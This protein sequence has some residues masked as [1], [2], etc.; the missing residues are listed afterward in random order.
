MPTPCV[1]FTNYTSDKLLT[2][3]AGQVL[4]G[5]VFLRGR[6][7]CREWA[8]RVGFV[9]Q[10]MRQLLW[11][12]PRENGYKK[13]ACPAVSS[14]R[15]A[16]CLTLL[17]GCG[18]AWSVLAQ[19]A[20]P[21]SAE[22]E[23]DLLG[24]SH[25][26]NRIP[27]VEWLPKPQIDIADANAD[28]ETAMKPYSEFIPGDDKKFDMVP[29]P[30]GQFSMGSPENEVGRSPNEGPQHEVRIAPFWMGKCE[31]TWDEFDLWML[32]LDHDLRVVGRR[33]STS[34]VHDKLADALAVP[35]M[36]YSDPTCSMGHEGYP[37]ILMT[38]LSAKLYCKWLSAK[39]GR[40]YR[41]P[42]EAEWEY[43]CR[44][45]TRTAYHFGDDPKELEQ[46]A[47]YAENSNEK[48][49]KVGQKKPNAWGLYDM[50]GNV[51]E[52]VLDGV[53]LDFY[54]QSA[55]HVVT[56]PF[57]VPTSTYGRGAR[58]GSWCDEAE[59][60][61]SAARRC[62]TTDWD[63]QNQ[64]IPGRPTWHTDS[65]FVGFRVVRPLRLPSV[66]ECEKLESR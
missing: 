60:L 57:A 10:V 12:C 50:H 63:A 34:I 13:M 47:W 51:A 9:Q 59:K 44:A 14:A 28:N 2:P 43:A 55:G 19:D 26:L 25:S 41:L 7:V 64:M 33:V 18:G 56:E 37:A 36:P 46:Y 29:I 6:G 42:T 20:T 27:T 17:V 1:T 61:R 16:V 15:V 66:E 39:T 35:S 40:Y 53:T 22:A 8:S 24:S 48:Y 31:V 62:S 21:P 52:W 58:G 30:G 49:H 54:A 3:R 5:L 38:Q 65:N 4:A 45:G 11:R 23:D 32:R